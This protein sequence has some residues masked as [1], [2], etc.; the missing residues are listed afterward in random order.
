MFGKSDP[1][2]N[3]ASLS[4]VV[5]PM[6]PQVEMEEKAGGMRKAA[7][8][9]TPL[10]QLSS[11]ALLI[12][13]KGPREQSLWEDKTQ[14]Q[15]RSRWNRKASPVQGRRSIGRKGDELSGY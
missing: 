12:S 6:E 13:H 8:T 7:S 15:K 1:V 4:P 2:P 14:T 11:S 9:P 10:I 5:T 3:C